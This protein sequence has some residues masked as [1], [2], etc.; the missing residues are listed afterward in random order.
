M[1]TVNQEIINTELA[2]LEF[3]NISCLRL[4]RDM[5]IEIEKLI[6]FQNISCLRLM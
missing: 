6:L 2:D 3:Q 1:F 5:I 4:I